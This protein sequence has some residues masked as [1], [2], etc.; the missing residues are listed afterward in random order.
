M[1]TIETGQYLLA[2][3]SFLMFKHFAKNQHF[4]CSVVHGCYVE[5]V[6]AT[7]SL[8]VFSSSVECI[9]I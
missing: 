1:V 3:T 7:E 5:K 9:I 2:V 8:R 4:I 6:V